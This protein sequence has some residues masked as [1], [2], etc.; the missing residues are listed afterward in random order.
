[1][2]SGTNSAATGQGCRVG[3]PVSEITNCVQLM[4]IYLVSGR[5]F[6]TI[7]YSQLRTNSTRWQTPGAQSIH[8]VCAGEKEEENNVVVD[9]AVSDLAHSKDH[10]SR[11]QNRCRIP[12]G[13]STFSFGR[14]HAYTCILWFCRVFRY[15]AGHFYRCIPSFC[16]A[17][18][19]Q[20]CRFAGFGRFCTSTRFL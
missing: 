15:F 13:Q 6:S 14:V 2:A 3:G 18:L 7:F 19:P 9:A 8:T 16:K 17:R 20:Y 4:C 11:C 1:M 10:V 12:R 5:V